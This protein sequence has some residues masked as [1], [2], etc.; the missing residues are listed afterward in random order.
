[1]IRVY[2]GAVLEENA[3]KTGGKMCTAD[4]PYG[5]ITVADLLV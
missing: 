1:M 5:L 3:A 4:D 2:D